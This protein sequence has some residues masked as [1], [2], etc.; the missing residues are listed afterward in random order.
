[1]LRAAT[2]R[3][4]AT[5]DRT[6]SRRRMSERVLDEAGTRVTVTARVD[7]PLAALELCGELPCW[8]QPVAMER[9][10]SFWQAHL[11]LGTGVYEIKLR[12][13]AGAWGIDPAWRTI[14]RDGE[15]NGV[16]VVGGCDE[17]VL[18]APVAPWLS[19]Q[20]DG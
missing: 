16:L 10:G 15:Q 2:R 4:A 3:H 9:A 1:R 17:P 14:G 6:D 11:R 19:L 20:S 7:R 12:E 13:P 18:H 5:H 8:E